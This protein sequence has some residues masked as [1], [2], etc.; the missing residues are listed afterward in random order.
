M[1]K[2]WS[3]MMIVSRSEYD[4]II[5]D[6]KLPESGQ[7]TLVVSHAEGGAN[8]TINVAVDVTEPAPMSIP[9]YNGCSDGG[10]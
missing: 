2:P 9:G 7:Y 5:A 3:V 6:Y 1:A 8:G 10:H 4:S